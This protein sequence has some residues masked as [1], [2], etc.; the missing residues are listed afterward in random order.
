M[1]R[2]LR[3]KEGYAWIKEGFGLYS[4]L[5]RTKEVKWYKLRSH[6]IN[7]DGCKTADMDLMDPGPFVLI[8]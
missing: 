1:H 6:T 2:D 4:D 3:S 8:L 5:G 7:I